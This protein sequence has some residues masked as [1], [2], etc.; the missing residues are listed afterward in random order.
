MVGVAYGRPRKL[1]LSFGKKKKGMDFIT[2]FTQSPTVEV[3]V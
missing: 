3:R 1:V 2:G